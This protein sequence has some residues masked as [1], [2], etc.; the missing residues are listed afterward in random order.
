MLY[1]ALKKVDLIFIHLHNLVLAVMG[2]NHLKLMLFDTAFQ[3]RC[4]YFALNVI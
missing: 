1:V 2:T 4:K 3:M